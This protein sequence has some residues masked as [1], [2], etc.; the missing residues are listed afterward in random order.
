[1]RRRPSTL[2][3]ARKFAGFRSAR[4]A[5][6]A[7]SWP[8]SA[9]AAHE[10][11]TRRP[12]AEQMARYLEAFAIDPAKLW[13]AERYGILPSLGAGNKA[14]E[15]RRR[16]RRLTLARNL[17]GFATA[18]LAADTYKFNEQNYYAHE[19]GRHGISDQL[20]AAY[21]LAFGVSPRWLLYGDAPSGLTTTS[22]ADTLASLVN[23]FVKSEDAQISEKLMQ[24][25]SA[26]RR[27]RPE[28]VAELRERKRQSTTLPKATSTAG[29]AL[30]I[31]REGVG[32]GKTNAWGFPPGFLSQVWRLPPANLRI[33][34]PSPDPANGAVSLGDRVLIDVEDVS[35][36]DGA[37][38]AVRREDGTIVLRNSPSGEMS[39]SVELLGRVVARISRVR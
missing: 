37:E 29:D 6:L 11:G 8:E 24:F 36:V 15:K 21:A 1:M 5:A 10:A 12:S 38:M 17:A 16:A 30:E 27:A 19:S 32:E 33:V 31:V 7:F 2:K 9:Y 26:V 18:K 34:A 20:A 23:A 4:A 13:D 25:A 39:G 14:D 3:A 28:I 35:W 22:N